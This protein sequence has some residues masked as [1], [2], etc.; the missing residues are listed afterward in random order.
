MRS[1]NKM[2]EITAETLMP[3]LEKASWI[4]GFKQIKTRV[5]DYEF[6]IKENSNYTTG[7]LTV[8]LFITEHATNDLLYVICGRVLDEFYSVYGDGMKILEERRELFRS[9][10]S[11]E[12]AASR[13]DLT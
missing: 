1:K 3:I 13:R 9:F 2:Q 8:T 10:V 5:K 6:E 7:P 11:N 12:L 4:K